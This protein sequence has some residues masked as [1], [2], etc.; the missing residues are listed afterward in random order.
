ME[1]REQRLVPVQEEEVVV[2]VAGS[3]SSNGSLFH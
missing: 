2:E 1:E 3:R